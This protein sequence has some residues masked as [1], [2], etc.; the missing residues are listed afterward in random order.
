VSS[1]GEAGLSE[2]AVLFVG[3][4]N[5]SYQFVADDVGILKS[6]KPNSLYGSE[7]LNGFDEP[8]FTAVRKIDLSRVSRD[9]AFGFGPKPSQ[10]HKHLFCGGILTFVED[11]E[12][13]IQGSTAHIGEGSD[14]EDS[15]VHEFL[16]LFH[17]EH[18]VEGI[19]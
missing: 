16:D 17:V 18:I 6:D 1:Q 5:F 2:S 19:I 11:D 7:G 14:F 4:D 12:G 3:A 9:N 15:L 10:K 13:S 8:R